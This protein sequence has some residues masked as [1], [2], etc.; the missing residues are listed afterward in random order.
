MDSDWEEDATAQAYEE[1][2]DHAR[3]LALRQ[4][5]TQVFWLHFQNLIS[6][7]GL[8]FCVGFGCIGKVSL[9]CKW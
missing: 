1:G 3:K 6:H 4:G 2:S 7:A 8:G 5:Q 9:P